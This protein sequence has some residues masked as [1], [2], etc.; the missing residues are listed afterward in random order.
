MKKK[1]GKDLDRWWWYGEDKEVLMWTVIRE[2][3]VFEIVMAFCF[4]SGDGARD[5]SWRDRVVIVAKDGD[6]FVG[7]FVCCSM[8]K[9]VDEGESGAM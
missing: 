6:P 3:H 7:F 9:V 4:C 2:G 1:K 8:N 5:N